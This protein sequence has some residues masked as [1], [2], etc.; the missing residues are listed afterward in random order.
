VDSVLSQRGTDLEYVVVDAGSTDRS[1]EYLESLL[2]PRLR[3]IFEADG[4]PADG[5]NKGVR[6]TRGD[7]VGYLNADDVYLAGALQ[8]VG[9]IFDR[10]PGIDVVYGDGWII[11][12]EGRA[13]RHF[14]STPWGL[15][16][17]LRGGVN[18]L[19]QSTFFRRSVFDRTA[20]FNTRNAT[21][22]DGELL[23]DLALAGARFR[24]VRADW[25]AF[26]LHRDGISGSGR[27]ETRYREDRERFVARVTGRESGVLDTALGYAARGAKI[28]RSPGYPSRRLLARLPLG[29]RLTRH[30]D[31]YILQSGPPE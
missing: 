29:L 13:L 22:W 26:R 7:V 4:G 30:E 10:E 9:E 20:G 19:Q 16:R 21:C 24:H 31:G 12:W 6:S 23:A 3:L 2:D 8:A 18:V 5:L 17:Y 1:R 14:E 15:R 28:L 11:D 27:L 25:S